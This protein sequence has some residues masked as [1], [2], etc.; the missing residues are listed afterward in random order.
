MLAIS[1]SAPRW[2]FSEYVRFLTDPYYLGVLA[3]SLLLGIIVACLTVLFGLPLAYWLARL[4]S[5]W[6]PALLVI[7]TFPLWI[8][9]VVRS[10]GWIVLL[11]R[12][13]S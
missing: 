11:S 4:Q 8:S 7:A 5:R 13:G 1:L 6:A 9:S 2:S 3:R 12:S 10:F